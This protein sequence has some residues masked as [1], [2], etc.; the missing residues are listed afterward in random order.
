MK[1]VAKALLV[2]LFSSGITLAQKVP[3]VTSGVDLGT[4]YQ[5]GEWV[6][7]VTYHQELSLNNFSWFRIGWGVRAWGYYAGKSNLLPQNNTFSKDTLKLGKVTANGISFLIGANF[8][9]GRFDIGANTDLIG[10]AFGLKRTSLYT[11]NYVFEGDDAGYYNKQV[12]SSPGMFNVVPLVM[13]K[14]NGQ[15]ELFVRYWITDR[16]GVKLG[17]TVGRITYLTSEKL[18]NGQNRFSKTYG[19]PYAAISFPIH[20]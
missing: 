10:L 4:G 3:R 14:Q 7:S 8:R 17:Y 1:I 2:I 6:P 20:Q 16:I 9:F 11:K 19:V 5:D 12:K 18:D 13:D 15:S